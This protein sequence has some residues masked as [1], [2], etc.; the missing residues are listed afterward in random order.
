[1]DLL[2]IIILYNFQS[3][4]TEPIIYF[5]LCFSGVKI[6]QNEVL[7]LLIPPPI[8]IHFRV[9]RINAFI[10]TIKKSRVAFP[11]RECFLLKIQNRIRIIFL[12]SYIDALKIRMQVNPGYTGCEFRMY[13]CIP[14]H[15]STCIISSLAM[16]RF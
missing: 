16:N 7:Y 14:L 1:M 12:H 10:L 9:F 11:F 6:K 15:R 5:E 3:G 4:I 2:A 8:C 13:G